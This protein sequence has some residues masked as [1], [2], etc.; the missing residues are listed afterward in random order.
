[1]IV[2]TVPFSVQAS[3]Q[4]VTARKYIRTPRPA[5]QRAARLSV[6]R[7]IGGTRRGE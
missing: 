4:P 6:R 3:G 5:S 1:M 7:H 2:I